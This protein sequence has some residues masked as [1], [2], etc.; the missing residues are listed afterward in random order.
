MDIIDTQQVVIVLA[1][2]A[3]LFAVLW[4]TRQHRSGLTRM[5]SSGN[6]LKVKEVRS[7]GMTTQAILLQ[8][9]ERDLLVISGR[10]VQP[11]IHDLGTNPGAQS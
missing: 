8:V 6:R 3:V 2:L 10:G 7:L 1:F 9:D 5:L 11:E 4:F